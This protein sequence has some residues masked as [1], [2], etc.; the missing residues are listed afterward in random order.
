MKPSGVLQRGTNVSAARGSEFN[1][2][3]PAKIF[4]EETSRRFGNIHRVV[5]RR[6]GAVDA[7]QALSDLSV[8]SLEALKG[9]RKGQFSIRVND[10][11]RVCFKWSDGNAADVEIVDYH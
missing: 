7:A 11:F 2:N 8:Y 9:D 3:P 4:R 10:Q 5:F 1:S 6:L